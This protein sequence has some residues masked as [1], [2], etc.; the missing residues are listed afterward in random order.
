[1]DK[2][3]VELTL[4]AKRNTTFDLKFPGEIDQINCSNPGS[5]GDSDY[6]DLYR[7]V[8]LKKGEQIT[9]EVSF[10]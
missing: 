1:M 10:K 2:G 4:M 5:I 3:E 7:T 9:L 8:N 6:G